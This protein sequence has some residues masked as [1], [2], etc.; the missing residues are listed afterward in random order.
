MEPTGS[1]AW[2]HKTSRHEDM[3]F[4]LDDVANFALVLNNL[5]WAHLEEP[6]RDA[7]LR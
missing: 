4:Q 2:S 3:A 5:K 6:Q 7:A 1:H